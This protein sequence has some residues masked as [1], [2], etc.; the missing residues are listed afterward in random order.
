MGFHSIL[1]FATA[2]GA[3]KAVSANGR[4]I[5]GRGIS[6]F[7]RVRVEVGF[8]CR[9]YRSDIRCEAGLR[10][11][12]RSSRDRSSLR[13]GCNARNWLR[14]RPRPPPPGNPPP[15]PPRLRAPP[16][17]AAPPGAATA[18]GKPPGPPAFPRSA[19]KV[20][21]I[22]PTLPEVGVVSAKS[23]RCENVELRAR[24][25]LLERK[26]VRSFLVLPYRGTVCCRDRAAISSTDCMRF[27]TL[28]QVTTL[29]SAA[30]LRIDSHGTTFREISILRKAPQHGHSRLP[31][32]VPKKVPSSSAVRM[33]KL[34]A[35]SP[36][37]CKLT[38]RSEI[39][40]KAAAGLAQ[41]TVGG[42][43]FRERRGNG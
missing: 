25:S 16:P 40:S 10:E 34:D 8:A 33:N 37:T 12:R 15:P 43:W 21:S 18:T 9:R 32:I 38:T 27:A 17:G 28:A 14:P 5:A 30:I 35:G 20:H 29:P 41:C 26:R 11:R 23:L 19:H 3:R 1:P 2:D 24:R 36:G 6:E 31:P 22:E 7:Q 4:T 42:L 39:G 13:P